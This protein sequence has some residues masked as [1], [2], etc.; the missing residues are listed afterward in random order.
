M[1][2]DFIYNK[3]AMNVIVNNWGW[4]AYFWRVIHRQSLKGIEKWDRELV[5]FV[6]EILSCRKGESLLDLVS[7]IKFTH[8]LKASSVVIIAGNS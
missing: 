1:L 7:P 5:K 2:I 4:W 6:V 3:F 8:S